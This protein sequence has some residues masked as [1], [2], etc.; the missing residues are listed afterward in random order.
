MISEKKSVNR[1]ILF[2]LNTAALSLKE[3]GIFEKDIL[4]QRSNN[5]DIFQKT[6]I[7]LVKTLAKAI[8]TSFHLII[9]AD[10][11]HDNKYICPVFLNIRSDKRLF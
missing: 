11:Q 8:T 6:N 7:F 4:L 2:L 3:F 1:R 9:N 5:T 10:K